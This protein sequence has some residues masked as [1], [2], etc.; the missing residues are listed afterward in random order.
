MSRIDVAV[1]V[2]RD[3]SGRILIARRKE[4]AHQGGLWEF[5][6]GKIE[7]AESDLQALSRELFEELNIK[8]SK[9]TPLIR[10]NFSYPDRHVQLYVRDVH[11]FQGKPTGREGQL[12][13][14]VAVQELDNYQFPAANKAIVSAI[15]LA[16]HYAIIGGD[17]VQQVLEQLENVFEQGITLVQIRNKM[18]CEREAEDVLRAVREACRQLGITYLISSQMSIQ[19]N[20]GDG[21]HLTS[22]DLLKLSQRPEGV[23]IV[24]ASCH[25]L[26]ELRKAEQLALDFAVLSPVMKTKSHPGAQVLGWQNFSEW[27]AKVNIPVFALGGL[28][29]RDYQKAIQCGAQGISGISL[30]KGQ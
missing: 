30:Y 13:K 8:P 18:L 14:W 22:D 7:A 29:K 4:D 3:K 9:T 24:A 16:K 2:V 10:I 20:K 5:P 21:V 19:R 17:C 11:E 6:G 1:G 15:K 26:Q 28:A 23:G 27:V 25:S 12:F